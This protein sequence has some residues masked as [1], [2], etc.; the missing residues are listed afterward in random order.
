[1]YANMFFPI[2]VQGSYQLVDEGITDVK[3]LYGFITNHAFEAL[4]LIISG[5]C[6]LLEPTAVCV[7]PFIYLPVYLC[8]FTN[9]YP[10][11]CVPVCLFV[12]LSAC[13]PICLIV[14]LFACLS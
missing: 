6:F 3:L 8:A 5:D 12:C 4:L 10:L 14:C 1:M 2:R 7:D 9:K 13:L 11:I